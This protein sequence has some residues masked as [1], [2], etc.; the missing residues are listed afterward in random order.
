[1]N[2]YTVCTPHQKE[3]LLRMLNDRYR[4]FISYGKIDDFYDLGLN[5]SQDIE[6]FR[7]INKQMLGFRSKWNKRNKIKI[8]LHKDFM[9][10][11]PERKTEWQFKQ[12]ESILDFE[13]KMRTL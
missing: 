4:D 2:I 5:K 13:H 12:R 9:F 7:R 8:P 6:S 10:T 1:M 3:N 11:S